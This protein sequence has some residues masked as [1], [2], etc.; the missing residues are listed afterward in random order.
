MINA[1]LK[2]EFTNFLNVEQHSKLIYNLV[3]SIFC[4]ENS[5]TYLKYSKHDRVRK[6]TISIYHHLTIT[7]SIRIVAVSYCDM[8]F[9]VVDIS[10]RHHDT[11]NHFT[12]MENV[13][14]SYNNKTKSFTILLPFVG[15]VY[16]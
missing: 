5:K 13:N 7:Y 3:L 4:D 1:L 15:C 9:C 16:A 2:I 11:E 6:P 8:N 12:T 10:F 14:N